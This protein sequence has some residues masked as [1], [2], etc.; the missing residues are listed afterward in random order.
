MICVVF[1]CD[2]YRGWTTVTNDNLIRNAFFL[3]IVGFTVVSGMIGAV[4]GYAIEH[5]FFTLVYDMVPSFTRLGLV[6]GFVTS[7]STC[8]VFHAAVSTVLVLYAESPEALKDN[9]P[10]EYGYLLD[11]WSYFYPTTAVWPASRVNM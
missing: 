6:V 10:Y 2:I 4:F 9:H 5:F 7:M 11:Q 3:Y 1:I 8:N